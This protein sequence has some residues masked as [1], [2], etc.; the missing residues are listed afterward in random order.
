MVVPVPAAWA[1][2]LR[3]LGGAIVLLV[4]VTAPFER[5][6]LVRRANAMQERIFDV[7]RAAS[8]RY[9]EG[10]QRDSVAVREVASLEYH[11]AHVRERLV[12]QLT[13]ESWTVRLLVIGAV[14]WAAGALPR[15]RVQGAGSRTSA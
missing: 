8:A 15:S 3:V 6:Y 11:R 7:R 4:L 1:R 12:K 10:W 9:P 14:I 5:W 2:R 13:T